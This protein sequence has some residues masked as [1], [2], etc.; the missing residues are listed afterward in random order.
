MV[1]PTYKG[2]KRLRPEGPGAV[3]EVVK[4]GDFEAQ[5]DW[6]IGLARRTPYDVKRDGS[7]VTV[8]FGS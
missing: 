8:T 6:A 3:R 4:V 2:P 5:L 1:V 7:R